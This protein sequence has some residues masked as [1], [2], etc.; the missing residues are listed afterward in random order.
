MS[1]VLIAY[2][3]NSG[4]TEEIARAMG[5]AIASDGEQV[6]VRRLEEVTSVGGYAAVLVGAP[7]IFGWHQSATAFLHKHEYALSQATGATGRSSS[8]G[9]IAGVPPQHRVPHIPL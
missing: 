4:S 2:S 1:T 7:M 3:T 6:D 5:E 9:H 8:S